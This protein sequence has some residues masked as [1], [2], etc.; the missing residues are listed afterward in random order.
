MKRLNKNENLKSKMQAIINPCLAIIC[1][2]VFTGGYYFSN[3]FI[4]K[5]VTDSEFELYEQ[6]A[7]DVYNQFG[8]KALYEIPEGVTLEKNDTSIIVSSNDPIT[9]GKV[10]AMKQ[11]GDLILER[12]LEVNERANINTFMGI[13][14]AFVFLFIVKHFFYI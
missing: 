3:H 13:I 6:V 1:I 5:T 4:V 9:F 7:Y 11:D 8:E 14:F 12:D 10:I 2:A